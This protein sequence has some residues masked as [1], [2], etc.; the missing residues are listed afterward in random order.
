MEYI[1]T[2][3]M[4]EFE[5]RLAE[6]DE[7]ARLAARN[8]PKPPPPPPKKT[9]KELRTESFRIA[10]KWLIPRLED[11]LSASWT[12]QSLFSP[13]HGRKRLW[14]YG[15]AWSGAWLK[16][17][18]VSLESDGQIRFKLVEPMRTV[19]QS[20]YPPGYSHQTRQ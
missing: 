1:M 3:E 9:A 15:L 5:K 11:L 10:C 2:P 12:L 18:E 16:A 13:G 19:F 14:G 4:I 20:A 8:R 17:S 7:R 6:A